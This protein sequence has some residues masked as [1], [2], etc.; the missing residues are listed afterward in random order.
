MQ[1]LLTASK[2]TYITNKIINNQAKS[3]NSNAGYA[4]T[5]DLFKLYEE[6]GFFQDGNYVTS[7]VVEKSALLIKFDYDKIGRLTSSIL[8]I[9]SAKFKAFLEL[10]DVS[11]GLQ[12]P[13]KFSALCNP[14]K[15]DFEEGYGIDVSKFEDIGSANYLT[16]S[17]YGA[18]P[19]KWNTPGAA[20]AG[21]IGSVKS[22]GS[23]TVTNHA[24]LTNTATFSLSDGTNTVL[25]TANPAANT[26]AR[27]NA[28]NYTFGINGANDTPTVADRI[29]AAIV[30]AKTGDGEDPDLN[31]TA[32]DPG[33]GS[34]VNLKQDSDGPT[35]NT[36]IVLGGTSAGRLTAV[37]FVNGYNE[38]HLDCITSGSLGTTKTDFGSAFYFDNPNDDLILD[39]TTAVSSSLKGLIANNGFRVGFSGSFD[40]D[41]KTRFVKRF[42]SR[43]VAN[44][45]LV[46]K[47]RIVFQDTLIDSS[48]N[49]Y[50]DTPG[51]L[52]FRARMGSILTSLVNNSGAALEGDNCGQVYI[53][54]GSYNQ[55]V[56]FSQVNQSSQNDR[57]RGVYKATLTI[58]SNNTYVKKALLANPAGFD[59]NVEWRTTDSP[60]K[61][62]KKST[63]F[64]KNYT[65][66][67]IK[68]EDIVSNFLSRKYSYSLDENIDISLSI[69]MNREDYAAL[70]TRTK[71]DN[72][73]A[74]TH[75]RVIEL[76][77]REEVIKYD[78]EYDSTLM[79][80]YDGNYQ[81]KI[82][83]GTLLPGFTYILEVCS[84]IN[85]VIGV[86]DSGE[87][88]FHKEK[89][90]FK[91]TQ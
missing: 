58:P 77:S 2:D 33:D 62:L 5:L 66:S 25:F 16:S 68:R 32:T 47:L 42:A 4:S 11:S 37:N 61:V 69:K 71:L 49:M 50:M 72:L 73:H 57:L 28:T 8:D 65:S 44:K 64:V 3:E 67:L 86:N 56:N 21:G 81:A 52:Y 70:K 35:G 6:S 1:L 84:L 7:G 41:N 31:I 43:H 17:F 9:K 51:D 53:S 80:V 90:K 59:V 60:P 23:I 45:L 14:L 85:N 87:K 91:V 24:G 10:R 12:K 36:N 76:V 75:Y 63:M 83:A 55:T 74:P 46:P 22:A 39:V 54:S 88:F 29:F 27:T 40:T 18:S 38:D 13:Y 34:V 48:T 79:S 19:V 78:F 26:P 15:N 89:F 20:S 82:L 30:A